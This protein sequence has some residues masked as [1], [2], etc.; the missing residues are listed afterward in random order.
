MELARNTLSLYG[1]FNDLP[2]FCVAYKI[3]IDDIFLRTL[4]LIEKM[5][6]QYE[7][8]TDKKPERYVFLQ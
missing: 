4:R 5:V 7:N 1:H 2:L 8:Q 3:T 6:E